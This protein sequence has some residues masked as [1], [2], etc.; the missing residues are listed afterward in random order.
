MRGADYETFNSRM[1]RI[2]RRNKALARGY[3]MSIDH[4][5]LIVARPSRRGGAIPRLL[6]KLAILVMAFKVVA[7][8]AI[9]AE[10]YTSRVQILS[11]GTVAE[12]VAAWVMT[13]D[14]VTVW[15]SQEALKLIAS[16]G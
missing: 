11:E 5:G 3:V 16:F 13:A 8:S 9:G 12:Q 7:Y 1:R 4:D 14:P 6:L 15:L 2:E 10:E